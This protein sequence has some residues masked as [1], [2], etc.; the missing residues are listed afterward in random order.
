M[1]MS[2]LR[3]RAKLPERNLELTVRA[4]TIQLRYHI[5]FGV[6]HLLVD[7]PRRVDVASGRLSEAG[8]GLWQFAC[9]KWPIFLTAL[10]TPLALV[11]LH[12]CGGS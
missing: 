3:R 8:A 2:E 6:A 12:T 1:A 4:R 10:S 7:W 5:P 11:L 9:A